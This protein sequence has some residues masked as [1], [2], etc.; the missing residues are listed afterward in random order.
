MSL[1]PVGTSADCRTARLSAYGL[2]WE[3]RAGRACGACGKPLS[4]GAVSRGWV[5]GRHGAH[6]LDVEL[7]VCPP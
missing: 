7:W 5:R 6:V 4:H 3:Q 2:T 1:V